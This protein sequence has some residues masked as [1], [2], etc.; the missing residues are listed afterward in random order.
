[1]AMTTNKKSGGSGG[2]PTAGYQA[3]L[4]PM[5]DATL[6]GLEH[7]L[8]HLLPAGVASRELLNGSISSGIFR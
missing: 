5:P 6:V 3:E 7:N 1:M 8:Q 2:G 4:W